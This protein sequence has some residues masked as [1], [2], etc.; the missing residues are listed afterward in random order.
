MCGVHMRGHL[1]LT[2]SVLLII[3]LAILGL[4]AITAS[5]RH[6]SS[7]GPSA[8]A[9][10]QPVGQDHP[11]RQEGFIGYAGDVLTYHYNANRQGQNTLESV[12]TP[13]NVNSSSFGKVGF[14]SVDGKV[15]AQPLYVYKLPGSS[16]FKTLYLWSLKMTAL[17]L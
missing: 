17:M 7:P 5:S 14:F 13:S 4:G 9:A 2:F 12:L 6:L 11:V 10:A 15:D 1:N 3:G 8:L 16:M